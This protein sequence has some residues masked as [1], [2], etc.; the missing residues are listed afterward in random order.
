MTNPIDYTGDYEHA[1]C[2][3][4]T[5]A[6]EALLHEFPDLNLIGHALADRPKPGS[7]LVAQAT[8]NQVRKKIGEL[9]RISDGS[10]TLRITGG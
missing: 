9:R 10:R 2:L 5:L 1:R 8:L 3:K 6:V 4:V 7:K